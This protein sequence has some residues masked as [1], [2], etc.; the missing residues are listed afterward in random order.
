[1]RSSNTSSGLPCWSA[2]RSP[3]SSRI[4]WRRVE[5]LA[6]ALLVTSCT[7]AGEISAEEWK[8]ISAL[9]GLGD[10]PP[11]PSNRY[12]GDAG[13]EL[14]GK[15]FYFDPRFSGRATL[16]DTLGRPRASARAPKGE[17]I[18]LACV[19]CH[20]PSR[21]GSDVTSIPPQVSI[22]AGWYDVNSQPTTNAAY[23]SIYY[24]NGR[25]DSLWSQV[26]AV[27]ESGVSMNADRV[28]VVRVMHDY[29]ASEYSAI[30]TEYPLP[31][32]ET[33]DELAARLDANGEC[34]LVNDAFDCMSAADRR[35]ITRAYV[36]FAKAIG[37][38]EYRLISRDSELDRWVAEGQT[39][40]RISDA[41]IRG[42]KLFVGKASCIDCHN[43]ALLSDMSWHNVGVPQL[44]DAVPRVA[45]CPK[46]HPACDCES[47]LNCLPFGIY[48]GL[49]RLKKSAFLRTSEWSDDPSDLSRQS[50]Y[51]LELVDRMKGAWRTPSFRDVALTAPYMHNGY[52]ATLEE[53]VQHYNLAVEGADAVGDPSVQIH[54]L[55]L[56]E[57]EESDL[58]AFLKTLTGA[59]VA[60]EWVRP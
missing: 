41:A 19:S 39:S 24:W 35:T 29:Y 48:D 16:V 25:S 10:P 13:A 45:D 31:F 49:S 44:G 17:P 14:L 28:Q 58:V 3:C 36:N 57:A 59:P 9:T 18:N 47:P 11:D 12:V 22:G 1:M 50:F 51:D 23:H 34:L 52:Y 5:A 26:L 32:S 54:P 40:E 33:S 37:A 38:Y 60:E 7:G 43:G 27:T 55:A 21:G 56:T 42:A 30:F 6:L 4:G 20:D 2:S 8:R 53:V 15:R 46:D